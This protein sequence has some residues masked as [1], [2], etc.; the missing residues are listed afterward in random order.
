MHNTGATGTT[1]TTGVTTVTTTGM[2]M[3]AITAATDG[4]I[5][6]SGRP[7]SGATEKG[8]RTAGVLRAIAIVTVGMDET[9][10]TAMA[11]VGVGAIVHSLDRPI[12]VVTM[13]AIATE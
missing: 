1:G 4:V 6:A 5:R 13:Q 9:V 7:I 3:T 11:T 10:T 2:T 12:R 8:L